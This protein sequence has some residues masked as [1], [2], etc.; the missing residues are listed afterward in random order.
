VTLFDTSVVIDARDA[1]SPW[2]EWARR[3]IADANDDDAAAVNSIV[4]AEAAVRVIDREHFTTHLEKMGLKL[5]PLPISVAAPAAKAY[6]RYLER[7]KGEGK[8][9]VSRIP[10]GDFLIGAQAEAEGME[11]VTRDPDRVRTYFPTVKLIVPKS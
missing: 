2:H 5:L 4:V 7:L 6:A 10:L 9:P 11:L 8:T 1:D 3:Q